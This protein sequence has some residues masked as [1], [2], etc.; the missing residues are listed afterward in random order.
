MKIEKKYCKYNKECFHYK[1]K[2][3]SLIFAKNL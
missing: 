3:E 1:E 2:K